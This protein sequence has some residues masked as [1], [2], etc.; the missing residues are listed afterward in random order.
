MS[1][2]PRQCGD[3]THGPRDGRYQDALRIFW[4]KQFVDAPGQPEPGKEVLGYINEKLVYDRNA[5]GPG[6]RDEVSEPVED[7]RVVGVIWK[8]L[9]AEGRT[10]ASIELRSLSGDTQI[11]ASDTA[12]S[13]NTPA[14]SFLNCVETR[15]DVSRNNGR[16]L[17]NPSETGWIRSS[18]FCSNVG[19]VKE[20]ERNRAGE[21]LYS[22]ELQKYRVQ[23]Q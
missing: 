17:H 10:F 22:M 12:V 14:G 7:T 11:R 21:M 15:E 20:V 3:L 6:W 2:S 4:L 18:V 16:D 9:P 19:L 8:V 5:L 1:V 13:L 23:K